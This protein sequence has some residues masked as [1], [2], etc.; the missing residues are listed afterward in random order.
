M[1]RQYTL[2]NPCHPRLPH[3]LESHARASAD[4]ITHWTCKQAPRPT[5]PSPACLL[6]QNRCHACKRFGHVWKSGHTSF[7]VETARSPCLQQW[8][9]VVPAAPS[10][11]RF[12]SLQLG[13]VGTS[14]TPYGGDSSPPTNE[15]VS[16]L[17]S[18]PNEPRDWLDEALRLRTTPHEPILC[19]E[20]CQ[21]Y[22]AEAKVRHQLVATWGGHANHHK[23]LCCE[24]RAWQKPSNHHAPRHV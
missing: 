24:K 9:V 2:V 15:G 4:P 12:C 18:W 13:F 10:L 22:M 20:A 16:Y 19:C 8:P 21:N 23:E 14:W 5:P 17:N 3:V 6:Q 11:N 1:S 7:G